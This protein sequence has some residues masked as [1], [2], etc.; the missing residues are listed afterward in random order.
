MSSNVTCDNTADAL[1]IFKLLIVNHDG[2][3]YVDCDN[4]SDSVLSLV[5]RMLFFDDVG[6]VYVNIRT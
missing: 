4:T 3:P 1:S 2:T 5:K 6:N